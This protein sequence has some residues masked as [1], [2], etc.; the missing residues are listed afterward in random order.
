MFDADTRQV[1]RPLHTTFDPM[2]VWLNPGICNTELHIFLNAAEAKAGLTYALIHQYMHSANWKPPSLHARVDAARV[3]SEAREKAS[4]DSFKGM[5]SEILAILPL[6][7][8]LVATT[9]A[10]CR[11]MQKG[12]HEF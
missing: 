3:F 5:A 9:L 12:A 11:E 8:Q 10:N 1:V 7:R 4:K 2:H 6:L